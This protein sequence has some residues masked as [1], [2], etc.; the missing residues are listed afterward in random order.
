MQLEIADNYL[1]RQMNGLVYEKRVKEDL[2]VASKKL[3]LI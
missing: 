1:A 2:D 3:L